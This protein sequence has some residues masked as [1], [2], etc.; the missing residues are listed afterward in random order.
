MNSKDSEI[1][2]IHNYLNRAKE[3]KQQLF[4]KLTTKLDQ[5][6][7]EKLSATSSRDKLQKRVALLDED[8]KKNN[9]KLSQKILVCERM[10]KELMEARIQINNKEDVIRSLYKKID[11]KF[12]ENLQ[13]SQK[14]KDEIFKLM[15]ENSNAKRNIETEKNRIIDKLQIDIED[16]L[17]IKERNL[18][19]IDNN[20]RYVFNLNEEI[21][22]I[23][24]HNNE[25]LKR[26]DSLELLNQGFFRFISFSF[27]II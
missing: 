27:K 4:V 17:Q 9:E 25:L 10:E 6:K 26:I 12:E 23:K 13:L 15:E 22:E 7:E 16:L 1:D 3:E 18:K 11:E 21:R 14:H 8:I 20:K 5:E 19:E 24:A 2:E